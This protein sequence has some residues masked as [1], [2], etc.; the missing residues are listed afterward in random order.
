MS[1]HIAEKFE[2]QGS[3]FDSFDYAEVDGVRVNAAVEKGSLVLSLSPEVLN[4]LSAGEH[5]LKVYFKDG[6]NAQAKYTINEAVEPDP[7][8]TPDP[9]PITPEYVIPIT[10]VE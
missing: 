5:E 6:L 3:T 1:D 2:E 9:T 8:P 7:T 10:G 4:A